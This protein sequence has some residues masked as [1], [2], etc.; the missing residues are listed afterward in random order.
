M[1]FRECDYVSC[2]WRW[3]RF[4][5]GKFECSAATETNFGGDCPPQAQLSSR[6]MFPL[7]VLRD[8]PSLTK[9]PVDIGVHPLPSEDN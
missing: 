2:V 5:L 9:Y 8:I 4:F 1:S 7:L 6:M 3:K